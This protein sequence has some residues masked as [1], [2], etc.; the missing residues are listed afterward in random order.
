MTKV[1]YLVESKRYN[2]II[3]SIGKI[4]LDNGRAI[5]EVDDSVNLI[6]ECKKLIDLKV[7]KASESDVAKPS[8]TEGN[9]V[10]GN[11]SSDT[12]LPVGALFK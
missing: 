9:I 11:A 6:D 4:E 5:V 12:K 3:T 7:S 1:K 8:T 2:N 10:S